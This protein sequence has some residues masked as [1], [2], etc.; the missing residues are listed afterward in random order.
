MIDHVWLYP[1][2]SVE[3][4]ALKVHGFFV[5]KAEMDRTSSSSRSQDRSLS[6]REHP[7]GEGTLLLRSNADRGKA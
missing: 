7:G 1:L 5:R 2:K 4:L 3:P 6:H